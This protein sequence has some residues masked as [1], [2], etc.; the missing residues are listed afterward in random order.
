MDDVRG[1]VE[2]LAQELQEL[3]RQMRDLLDVRW[4]LT[5]KN[6]AQLIENVEALDRRI[7]RLEDAQQRN[8]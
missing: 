6:F 2:H 5:A 7:A 4:D 1:V 3:K 8:D